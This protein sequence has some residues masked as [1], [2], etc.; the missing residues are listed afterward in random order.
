[1]L[2]HC[3]QVRKGRASQAAKGRRRRWVLRREGGRV[4]V[5]GPRPTEKLQPTWQKT[6]AGRAP[7]GLER[8]GLHHNVTPVLDG[9]HPCSHCPQPQEQGHT[10]QQHLSPHQQ[11]LG[12]GGGKVS[13][14]L[15]VHPCSE[16]ALRLT[17]ICGGGTN[18]TQ[19]HTG[20]HTCV[21]THAHT[22]HRFKDPRFSSARV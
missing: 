14:R 8:F 19:V 2:P 1:M 12:R 7:T 22:S 9:G 3:Y 17:Q 18:H 6:G 11:L 16:T 20:T 5:K 21:H 13:H 4:R 10:C 15:R